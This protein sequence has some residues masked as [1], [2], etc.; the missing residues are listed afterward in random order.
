M[1]PRHAGRNRGLLAVHSGALGDVILFGRLL[2][3]TPGPRTLIASGQKASLLK[4]AGVVQET[5]DF[6][7]LPMHEVFSS[8]PLDQCRL[9]GMLGGFDRLVSCL[10]GGGDEP[11]QRLSSL[12]GCAQ[13]TFLPVRPPARYDGHLV[14]LWLEMLGVAGPVSAAPWRFPASSADAYDG[15]TFIHPGSGGADKCWPLCLFLE[16]A[17][18]LQSSGHK[19]VFILGPV[20]LD[21]LDTAVVEELERRHSVL[22]SPSLARLA[23]LLARCRLYVGNDSGVSH[24]AAVAGASCV[25]LFGPS[26]SRHFA[27][28]GPKVTV[29]QAPDMSQIGLDAVVR[30]ASIASGTGML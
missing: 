5:L 22:R 6:D 27:P 2:E 26:S 7:L 14:S 23:G 18:V 25:V 30:S 3:M 15:C 28:I 11:S 1:K 29:I 12:C 16:L 9:A 8:T 24:L 21:R 13:A 17:D 20:E 4:T 19:P 10:G